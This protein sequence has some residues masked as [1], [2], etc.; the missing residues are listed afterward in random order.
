MKVR[1][2]DGSIVEGTQI[3]FDEASM[4]W[5][6]VKLKDGTILKLKIEIMDVIRLDFFNPQNGE[7]AY[8]VPT[9]VVVR[10]TQIPEKLRKLPNEPPK[11]T[12][13]DVQ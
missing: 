3:D 7:P 5:S 10:A 2:P 8:H 4:P 13:V 1:A 9:M 11:P 6:T 12:N